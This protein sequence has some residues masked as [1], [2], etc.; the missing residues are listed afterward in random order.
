MRLLAAAVVIMAVV[1]ACG[2]SGASQGQQAAANAVTISDDAFNPT[3]NTVTA[4]TTVTWTTTGSHGHTVTADDGS[5]DSDSNGSGATLATGSTFTHT[6]AAAGTFAYH[7]KV[8]SS[9]HG[10]VTVTP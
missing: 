9:M 4:G 2:S 6:F 7:C 3:G 10:T 1:A 5:F 8:H